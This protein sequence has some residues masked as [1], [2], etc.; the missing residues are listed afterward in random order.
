MLPT[1]I[2]AAIHNEEG[3]SNMMEILTATRGQWRE[4]A[5]EDSGFTVE[6]FLR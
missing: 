3:D 2:K 6:D 4:L 1:R 5:M